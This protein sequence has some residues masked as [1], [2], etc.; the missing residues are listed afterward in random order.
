MASEQTFHLTSTQTALA[1]VLPVHL[2]SEVNSLRRTHDKSYQKWP[3]HVNII[4]PFV[5]PEQLDHATTKL[6]DVLNEKAT[7]VGDVNSVDHFR[8]RKNAT[9][10]L[11]PDK[12]FEDG[13]LKLRD[14][15]VAAL[16][17]SSSE[18]THDGTYR[19]HLTIGQAGLAGDSVQKLSDL[20][21]GINA[22]HIK[23]G[24]LAVLKRDVT[25][26]M[27]VVRELPF[28]MDNEC[29]VEEDRDQNNK[30]TWQ[31]C[32]AFV[33]ST[34]WKK[35][36]GNDINSHRQVEINQPI[37]ISTYNIMAEPLA[38]PFKDRLPLII[39]AL[40][41]S[42]VDH[43]N[44]TLKVLCIQEVNEESLTLL[45]SEPYIRNTYPFSS[46]SPSTLLPSH[47]NLITLSSS[48]FSHF[49]LHFEELHKSSLIIYISGDIKIA[50]IHLSAGLLDHAI[51][52]KKSQMHSL[53]WFLREDQTQHGGDSIVAG[54][55]NLTTSSRT[56][57][58]ALAT[59]VISRTAADI[60]P[61][62]IDETIWEDSFTLFEGL[63][64][65][66]GDIFSG[67]EGAT[68]DRRTNPFAMGF[69]GR[70]GKPVDDSPQRY[71][72]VLFAKG[73]RLH[74]KKIERFGLPNEKG[75]C[76][77]DH[78][79]VCSTIHIE[80]LD[81][82]EERTQISAA[83]TNNIPEIEV[84]EDTTDISLLLQPFLATQDDRQVREDAIQMLRDAF[85]DH[86]SL[87]G[88]AFTFLGSYLM[89]T[90]FPDSDVD[91]LV[92]GTT[93]LQSFL[94]F[95][96]A[97]LRSDIHDNGEDSNIKE[98]RLVNS[99][100]PVL[101]VV[102]KGVKFDLQYCRAPEVLQ[103]Y[104]SETLDHVDIFVVL[105]H[106]EDMVTL[107]RFLLYLSQIL[108]PH[109]FPASLQHHCDP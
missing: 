50:N 78:Y 105:I 91:L 42:S 54:D 95:A 35:Y 39:N 69:E 74:A 90:H 36:S 81:T 56:I 31:P 92:I 75:K 77:S 11:K 8:H 64:D 43:S 106:L 88:L 62:I 3:P 102:I 76:G 66:E 85:D 67:E 16:G 107:L 51:T 9:I 101:K 6:S 108:I 103:R 93:T 25:G 86:S 33:D 41:S 23:V 15:L 30:T 22:L 40:S 44:K 1:F 72:R 2:Q 80:Q 58:K 14:D 73:G 98:I 84:V 63:D 59:G 87:G 45:L 109:F 89:D 13:L 12:D 83:V 34:G 96:E 60:I 24:S 47:R 104:V 61:T 28:R 94:D 71:D 38:T 100:I 17:C 10:F 48:H 65:T 18:G 32:Y 55:F 97:R 21:G 19:P 49:T 79:G 53:A 57:Q 46:H 99:L 52:S 27:K 82:P 68:Y 4:Y 29:E 70:F 26:K 37:T 7:I 20:A 5:D